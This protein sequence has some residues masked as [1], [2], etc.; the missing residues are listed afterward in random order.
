[1]RELF[2]WDSAKA[3]SNLRKHRISFEEGTSAFDDR[4]SITI[5][6]PDHSLGEQRY[7]LIG[8][9]EHNRILVVSHVERGR[10]VRIISVRVATASE[11]HLYEEKR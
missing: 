6:D 11:R 2:V 5:S 4:S 8:Y 7:L 10:L 3:A 9:S 1:M